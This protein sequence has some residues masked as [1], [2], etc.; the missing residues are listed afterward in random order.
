VLAQRL[1][2]G[3]QLFELGNGIATRF[4]CFDQVVYQRLRFAASPLRSSYPVWIET[5][6]LDINHRA[7][8]A[9]SVR[10]GDSIVIRQ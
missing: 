5:E 4:I 3:A 10:R 8:V 6:H 1:L 2:L 7:S 9:T